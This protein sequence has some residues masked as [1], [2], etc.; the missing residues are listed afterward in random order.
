MKP[1][2]LFSSIVGADATMQFDPAGL[3]NRFDKPF[4]IS[5]IRFSTNNVLAA[6]AMDVTSV[7]LYA[8]ATELTRGNT[9]I[10]CF[11]P[12]IDRVAWGGSGSGSV[13]SS[14]MWELA[15]PL[16]LPP[17][18]AIGASA[19]TQ[20]FNSVFPT[21]V[22][23]VPDLA[24]T[25]VGMVLDERYNERAQAA[26]PYAAAWQSGVAESNAASP[27]SIFANPFAQPLYVKG[28]INAGIVKVTG[29]GANS[30]N[31]DGFLGATT[32]GQLPQYQLV[33]SGSAGEQSKGTNFINR[34][35]ASA[36][37]LFYLPTREWRMNAVLGPKE[38]FQIRS[39]SSLASFQHRIG[40][41]GYRVVPGNTIWH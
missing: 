28:L 16:I 4:A 12:I 20:D 9:P 41:T 13:A 24:I 19:S 23:T 3:T 1:G 31:A 36:K 8:G 15:K 27:S 22:T 7:R 14:F 40:M 39:I 37:A 29:K 38:F 25:L 2:V 11:C 21:A 34:D 18:T 33:R 30:V 10:S 5:A 6:V 35:F 26:V 17:N 32:W